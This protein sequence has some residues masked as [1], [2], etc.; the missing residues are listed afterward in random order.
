M[1]TTLGA[2]PAKLARDALTASGTG[3]GRV[4]TVRAGG[5]RWL[6]ACVHRDDAGTAETALRSA[7]PGAAI[8]RFT[9]EIRIRLA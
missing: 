8:Q 2:S 4:H 7:F 9:S 5:V 1:T 3:F 6:V